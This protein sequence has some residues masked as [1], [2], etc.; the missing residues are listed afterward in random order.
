[1]SGI[2]VLGDD[3]IG[4]TQPVRQAFERL[5]DPNRKRITTPLP[6]RLKAP[7]PVPRPQLHQQHR[8]PI[9]SASAIIVPTVPVPR[10]HPKRNARLAR[11]VASNAPPPTRHTARRDS[12]MLS[13]TPVLHRRST[14]NSSS[15]VVPPRPPAVSPS[16]S[17][18]GTNATAASGRFGVQ[19]GA[20]H[21]KGE[22]SKRLPKVIKGLPNR[23]GEPDPIVAQY[24][25]ARHGTYFRA[26]LIGFESRAAAAQTCR[27]LKDRRTDCIILASAK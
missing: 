8:R 23:L 12:R 24:T 4:L 25:D 16:T 22:A 11:L 10:A 18:A 9:L 21:S 13:G 5:D 7:P 6:I 1:M 2:G 26:R 19:I 3:G 27:W 15:I 20:Y 14:A 17:K